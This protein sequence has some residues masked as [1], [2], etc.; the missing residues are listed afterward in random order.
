MRFILA[1]LIAC[2]SLPSFSQG[3]EDLP[4][5]IK[6][7]REYRREYR[8][9]LK[10]EKDRI[11]ENS[12]WDI[13]IDPIES[14]P[15]KRFA[16]MPD[17]D[18]NWGNQ[19]L[20]PPDVWAEL[21]SRA[22]GKV[23]IKIGD[24]GEAQHDDLK[25]GLL[26]GANYTTDAD[27]FDGHGHSTHVGGIVGANGFGL[28]DP[29]FD[30]GLAEIKFCKVLN[31]SGSGAF[32]WISNMI[33]TEDEDNKQLIAAGKHVVVNFSLGGGTSKQ[34]I[35]ETA[36]QN[37]V[38]LGV[39]YCVAAGNTGGPVEYPGNSSYVTGVSS[40]DQN[41]TISSFSS[42]GAEVEQT[43]PGRSIF[44]TYKG[45]TY[46]TLSGT[47]MA[48]PFQTALTAIAMSVYPN[49]LN[50]Q[51]EVDAY[52]QKI[53]KDLGTPGKDNLYGWG[54]VYVRAILDTPPDGNID[55]TCNIVSVEF[56]GSPTGCQ[57]NGTPNDVTDDYFT[58]SVTIV[59]GRIPTSGSLQIVPG[60]DQIGTYSIPV[61]LLGGSHTFNGVKFKADGTVTEI[62]VNFTSDPSC[63]H[64]GEGPAVKSCSVPQPPQDT[65][66]PRPARD[67]TFQVEGSYNMFWKTYGGSV[68][69][70]NITSP[71]VIQMHEDGL[72]AMGYGTI[73]ITYIEATVRSTTNAEIESARFKANMS[74][75]FRNRGLIMP[76][77]SDFSD[78]VYWSSF[79]LD[80]LLDTQSPDKEDITV[81]KIIGNDGSGNVVLYY[82]D[83]LRHWDHK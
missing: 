77:P 82:K 1:L 42:R 22:T 3:L 73:T 66:T 6:V 23:V 74:W 32:N 11:K 10:E 65:I 56:I 12:D 19:L 29:L 38:K 51:S 64:P 16:I 70:A 58:Q 67:V 41:L 46:A 55:P 2:I 18:G 75:F 24:T 78:A 8:K 20:L 17:A 81:R 48:T 61:N 57:D 83:T 13:V 34:A 68:S 31:N 7:D 14:V 45:N 39:V 26:P 44:S 54:L 9:L 30:K 35:V 72:A 37:S 71:M 62:N 80:M 50:N 53:S 49:Q 21:R 79:F 28:A 25:R 60:G 47:S 33:S 27:R 40:L 4:K 59:L 63:A 43:A 15:T 36:L 69:A 5:P 52:F 76:V